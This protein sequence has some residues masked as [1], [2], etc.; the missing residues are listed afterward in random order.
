MNV[1]GEGEGIMNDEQGILNVEGKKKIS[2]NEQGILNV[3]G[4]K[5]NIE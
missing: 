2:N 3:E 5:K 1:E 4:E